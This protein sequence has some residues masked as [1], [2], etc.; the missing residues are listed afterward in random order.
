M[1]RNGRT[2]TTGVSC[3]RSAPPNGGGAQDGFTLLEVLLATSLMA[4]GA[5]SVL[6]VLASAAGYATQRRTQ[7]SLTQVL[8]EARNHA[9]AMANAHVPSKEQPLPGGKQAAVDPRSSS[10]YPAFAY[11]LKF[12]HVDKSVPEAGYRVS[13]NVKYGVADGTEGIDKTETM[14]IASDTV[15]ASEFERSIT[16]DAQRKGKN[17]S[18]GRNESR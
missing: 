12:D 3:R 7:Q 6:V 18:S 10:L 14:V 2:T 16:Y 11:S 15:P 17:D 4:V 8:E 1:T 9:R 13:V 5:I